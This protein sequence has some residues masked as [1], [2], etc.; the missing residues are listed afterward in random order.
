M[1]QTVMSSCHQHL[2]K[3][4]QTL[5]MTNKAWDLV[6]AECRPLVSSL[7]NLGEQLRALDN[8]RL[9]VTPLHRFPDFKERL[10]FKLL[11]AVDVVLGKLTDKV[12]E[13][14]KLLK[15]LGIQVSAAFQFYE[16]NTDTLDLGTCTLRTATS[17]SIA[18]MLEWIQDAH[19]YYR[20]Q[21]QRRKHLLQVLKPDDLAAMEE[22][23]KRWESFYSPEGEERIEDT[24][25]RVSLFIDS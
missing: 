4:F 7:G 12:D 19:A 14:Q 10:R 25:S 11:L 2:K 21:F 3:C 5:D 22:V 15:T 13:F 8:V 16:Q 20:S 6:L 18:D 23:S 9:D 1:A 24:L 17:P